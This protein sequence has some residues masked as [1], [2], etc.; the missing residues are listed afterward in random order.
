MCICILERCGERE[1]NISLQV[2]YI[3]H[4]VYYKPL[5][6]I[7]I[8]FR[9]FLL[10]SSLCFSL[11]LSLSLAFGFKEYVSNSF[12]PLPE[13]FSMPPLSR[14]GSDHLNRRGMMLTALHST[15]R[16]T[17]EKLKRVGLLL[18]LKMKMYCYECFPF[19]KTTNQRRRI[20]DFGCHFDMC[21]YLFHIQTLIGPRV[22]KRTPIWSTYIFFSNVI[23]VTSHSSLALMLIY[24]GYAIHLHI[25]SII[26]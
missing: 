3:L 11:T 9:C 19:P 2:K 7:I 15:C 20:S 24:V 17:V 10:L 13:N 8:L 12:S 18:L 26:H 14:A 6:F 25:H 1:K 22:E 16:Y 23:F 5:L 4:P 21:S